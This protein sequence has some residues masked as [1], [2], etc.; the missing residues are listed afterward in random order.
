MSSYLCLIWHVHTRKFCVST[1][2]FCVHT[3]KT[4]YVF[5]PGYG[6]AYLA[7]TLTSKTPTPKTKFTKGIFGLKEEEAATMTPQE[8]KT[9]WAWCAGIGLAI[10]LANNLIT[11]YGMVMEWGAE[12]WLA[13]GLSTAMDIFVGIS[14]ACFDLFIGGIK[15]MVSIAERVG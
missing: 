15:L 11:A 8:R 1:R 10:E 2:K 5:T 13:W 4:T 7:T 9:Q 12:E 6:K 14:S 3:P